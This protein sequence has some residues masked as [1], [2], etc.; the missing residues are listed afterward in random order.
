MSSPV[1]SVSFRPSAFQGKNPRR[2]Q[3][4]P[5]QCDYGRKHQTGRGQ[6]GPHDQKCKNNEKE[7]LHLSTR[8]PNACRQ[9]M[10]KRYARIPME[11][12]IQV[13]SI[14]ITAPIPPLITGPQSGSNGLQLLGHV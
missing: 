14:S 2:R 4:R 7:R 9:T 11:A 10:G 12:L 8:R 13:K 6:P 5:H 3:D 1:Q